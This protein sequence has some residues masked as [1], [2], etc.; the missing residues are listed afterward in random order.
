VIAQP[1]HECA[2]AVHVSGFVPH[3]TVRVYANGTDQIGKETPHFAFADIAL[4]RNLKLG[5]SITA[6][7]TVGGISSL[8]SYFPVIV[9]PYIGPLNKPEAGKD[10]FACGRIVPVDKLVPSVKIHA[11][12]DGAE[13]GVANAPDTWQPVWTQSLTAGERVTAQQMA[14]ED[15]ATMGLVSPMSDPV[16]VKPDPQP[17]PSPTVDTSSLV[18]DNDAV[19][20]RD[21]YVGAE[22]QVLSNG[23]GIGGG[24]ATASTNWVPVNPAIQLNAGIKANQELC[25]PPSPDSPEV[26]PTSELQAPRVLGPICQGSQYAIIRDTV[27][28]ANVVL[29][30]NG[31][32]VGYGGAVPG[33]LI[34]AL[35][36]GAHF[37]AGDVVTARQY[38]GATVSPGSNTVT[39]VSGLGT[40]AVEIHG[41]EP[42]FLA[43]NREQAIDGPVFPRG[44]GTG[45]LFTIQACCDREVRAQVLGPDGSVVADVPLTQVV[46]GY[47]SGQWNWQSATGWAVPDGI[48]VGAYAVRVR[49]GCRQE[50]A[51]K[52]FYVIFDPEEV[53][54]PDRFSFNE[55]AIWFYSPSGSDVSQP[56]ELHPDDNRI[57]GQAIQLIN[58]ETSAYDASQKIMGWVVPAG[59]T[60]ECCVNKPSPP[61]KQGP[62][63]S[64]P[65]GKRWRY[66]ICTAEVDT[67]DLLSLGDQAAQCADSAS[68]LTSMLRAIGIPAHPSTADAG[69]EH[70]SLTGAFWGFDTWTEARMRGPQGEQ[71]YVAHPHEGHSFTPRSSAGT[72][73]VANKTFNDIVICANENWVASDVGKTVVTFGF[74]TPCKEPDEH[75][76]TKAAWV[77]HLCD[78]NPDGSYWDKGHWTCSPPYE[79]NVVF[80]LPSPRFLV[81]DTI[82]FKVEVRNSTDKPS[83][84]KLAVRIE[85]DRPR[86]K[87]YDDEILRVGEVDLR[88]PANGSRTVALDFALPATL[89]ASDYYTLVGTFLGGE[90]RQPFE[91]LTRYTSQIRLPEAVDVDDV[92]QVDAI[93]ENTGSSAVSNVRTTL[94]LPF[95]L[96]LGSDSSQANMGTLRPSEERKVSWKV[97]ARSPSEAALVTVRV[98]SSDGGR[99]TLQKPVVVRALVQQRPSQ[100]PAG[101]VIRR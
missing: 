12:G 46:P 10:L 36:G 84:G 3:A 59:N 66:S 11:F 87:M 65:A 38:I 50:P 67:L 52:R 79:P 2:E 96:S 62:I 72:W 57:F 24:F 29:F 20:L 14:C 25:G 82:R 37:A 31:A 99:M 42:F 53:T 78:G 33:D 93:V 39:V 85:V 19:T 73:S 15:V 23:A 49:S 48:P 40:P 45:P 54:A 97:L 94:D 16:A 81:G 77:E 13:I 17:L 28:N 27:I 21:L 89:A 92:F 7:Q 63:G 6:T 22:V 70:K 43:E 4:T 100:G 58:G 61:C 9:T 74:D 34:L 86:T 51:T 71:W 95:A 60:Y 56:Y 101:A 98:E 80:H 68:L 83:R 55:M 35:G 26:K 90:G 76:K 75:F 32:V 88:V 5:E 44:K 47:Y 41:G 1:I 69:K 18:V 8:H 91:V 64:L 30:R